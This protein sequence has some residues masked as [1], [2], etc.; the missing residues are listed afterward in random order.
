[1]S[2][3]SDYC[4]YTEF[5]GKGVNTTT[6]NRY[7][8]RLELLPA[9]DRYPFGARDGVAQEFLQFENYTAGAAF[10]Y[11]VG[12]VEASF[13]DFPTGL[14]SSPKLKIKIDTTQFSSNLFDVLTQKNTV[15]KSYLSTLD[16]ETLSVINYSISNVWCLRCDF[17]NV[18]DL[19]NSTPVYT[20]AQ[21]A[22]TVANVNIKSGSEEIEIETEHLLAHVLKQIKVEEFAGY[23]SFNYAFDNT[24]LRLQAFC[25]EE[26]YTESKMV[27]VKYG[28][29]YVNELKTVGI[30]YTESNRENKNGLIH[31]KDLNKRVNELVRYI[32][33]FYRVPAIYIKKSFFDTSHITFYKKNYAK[34]LAKGTALSFYSYVIS[35]DINFYTQDLYFTAFIFDNE[36]DKNVIG[37]LLKKGGGSGNLFESETLYDALDKF[38]TSVQAKAR[39]TSF[40]AE[41]VQRQILQSAFAEETIILDEEI[42]DDSSPEISFD[43]SAKPRSVK[44]NIDSEGDKNFDEF[45]SAITNDAE[46]A[47]DLE[48]KILFHNN[49]VIKSEYDNIT[50][51]TDITL[52]YKENSRSKKYSLRNFWYLDKPD[53]IDSGMSDDKIPIKVHYF[54]DYHTTYS[55][56][57]N[58]DYTAPGTLNT[59]DKFSAIQS[60]AG[61]INTYLKAYAAIFNTNKICKI[62]FKASLDKF[63]MEKLGDIYNVTVPGRFSY[64][65]SKAIL[66]YNKVNYKEHSA[67]VVLLMLPTIP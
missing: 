65:S 45:S 13:D 35:N 4:F 56:Y 39:F 33:G 14:A 59:I 11:E 34:D 54:A 3:I 38:I 18:I 6:G 7:K 17:G 43:F 24:T 51:E 52:D 23:V 9:S 53:F 5:T 66:I 62:K 30:A 37:G 64:L 42:L 57:F 58:I 49:P 21:K 50:N 63:S 46:S 32:S 55:Q 1:M 31:I 25:Y 15:T 27:P 29:H 2:V 36:T 22:G 61:L 28:N 19:A 44:Y 8:Y 40:E 12:E 16:G 10:W 47:Q 20:G 60:K 41:I 26:L 48:S 67:E